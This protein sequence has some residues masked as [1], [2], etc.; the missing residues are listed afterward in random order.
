M[1]E[2]QTYSSTAPSVGFVR[3]YNSDSLIAVGFCAEAR[4]ASRAA[5]KTAA[6]ISDPFLKF[7]MVQTKLE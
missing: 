1:C 2:D 3:S 6:S 4:L 7:L 5:V